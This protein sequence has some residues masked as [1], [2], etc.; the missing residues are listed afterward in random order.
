MIAG[1]SLLAY[2]LFIDPLP[3]W[4]ESWYWPLLIIPLS[5]GVALVYKSI[6]CRDMPMAFRES[7]GLAITI[8][9]GMVLAAGA[10]AGVAKFMH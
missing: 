9:V 7:I 3:I 2:T 5:A 6:R 1:F 4:R 8:I 10:L